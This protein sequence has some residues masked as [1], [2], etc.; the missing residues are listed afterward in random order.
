[1]SVAGESIS[2]S[3]ATEWAEIE[4]FWAIYFGK[5]VPV[6]AGGFFVVIYFKPWKVTSTLGGRR[7]MQNPLKTGF[8]YS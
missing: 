1:M 5:T 6:F 2:V 7:T 8:F 3:L 4:R